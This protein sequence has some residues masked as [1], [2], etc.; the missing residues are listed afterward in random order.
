MF[1][2]CRT[3]LHI[4]SVGIVY[5]SEKKAVE[6]IR[7]LIISKEPEMESF[8]EIFQLIEK[9]KTDPTIQEKD[10]NGLRKLL[11][12]KEQQRPWFAHQ[13]RFTIDWIIEELLQRM[14]RRTV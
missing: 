7:Q 12:N 5:T 1:L 10:L 3:D 11:E 9:Y 8:S 4:K 2:I 14:S 13:S 6:E